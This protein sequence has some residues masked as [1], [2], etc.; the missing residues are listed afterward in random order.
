MAASQIFGIN[1][2]S[3]YFEIPAVVINNKPKLCAA[4][5]RPRFGTNGAY[6]ASEYREWQNKVISYLNQQ[7][8]QAFPERFGLIFCFHGSLRA[9]ID[10]AIGALLD[11]FV[12]NGLAINDSPSYYIGSCCF[13]EPII[14]TGP[15]GGRKK[16]NPQEQLND[17]HI[18]CYVMDEQRYEIA[19]IAIF[20]LLRSWQLPTNERLFK[21]SEVLLFGR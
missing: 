20:D 9:D 14:K 8:V 17:Y 2:S 16:L 6:M 11:V 10:N 13:I 12:A 15:R 21:S 7:Q 1:S 5:E 18:K 3:Q 19:K 4:K